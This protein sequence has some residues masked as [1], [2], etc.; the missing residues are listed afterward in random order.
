MKVHI[1]ENIENIIDGYDMVPIIYGKI[2]TIN[3]YPDNS[4]IEIIAIDALDSIPHE[5]LEEF[6]T[7]IIRKMRMGC[8]VTFGGAELQIIARN[9]IA[10]KIDSKTF[11]EAI[12]KKKAI[13]SSKDIV[14][15]LTKGNLTIDTVNIR[16]HFY[17]IKAS[18][19]P[20]Q[21]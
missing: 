2:D 19:Q 8:V 20:N 16:G 15:L 10:G 14:D 18:R 6:L 21:N 5:M 3:K 17:E 9:V 13:Y 1:T 11:N 7:S 4:L 12:F